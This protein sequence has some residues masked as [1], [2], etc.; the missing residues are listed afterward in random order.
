M[1]GNHF[2]VLTLKCTHS[3]NRMFAQAP[4]GPEKVEMLG[5]S[6]AEDIEK[7]GLWNLWGFGRHRCDAG[8]CHRCWGGFCT[9]ARAGTSDIRPTWGD[10][11]AWLGHLF[12]VTSSD[13]L[14]TSRNAPANIVDPLNL[15]AAAADMA[16]RL[17]LSSKIL[18]EKDTVKIG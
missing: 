10:V 8:R 3:M 16:Q 13:A 6:S 14:V 11:W 12:E 18:D 4:K 1:K 5:Y 9:R 2:E 15:T 7:A 17:G